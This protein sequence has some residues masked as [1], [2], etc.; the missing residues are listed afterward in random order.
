MT[1][2]EKTKESLLKY[3]EG[4][5]AIVMQLRSKKKPTGK[6]SDKAKVLA[7]AKKF[8]TKQEWRTK[9]LKS[10]EAAKI[11]GYL[12]EAC[13]HMKKER[14]ATKVPAGFWDVKENTLNDARKYPDKREWRIKSGTAYQKASNN[15]WLKDITFG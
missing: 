2:N 6:W 14:K 11:L 15:G 5:E 3:V 12:D 4:L 8:K 7:K 10:F 9:S 1:H 13:A